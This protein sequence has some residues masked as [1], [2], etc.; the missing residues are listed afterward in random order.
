MTTRR[1]RDALQMKQDILTAANQIAEKEGFD[2]ISIRKIAK[3]IEYTPSLIYHYFAS[4]EEIVS[5]LLKQGYAKLATSLATAAKSVEAPKQK[6]T[7]MTRAFLKTALEIP[8]E[9][10]IV[11]TDD[12]ESVVQHTSYLFK[13]AAEKRIAIQMLARCIQDMNQGREMDDEQSE[14]T[15]QSI[16]AATMG[17]ALKLIVEK[18]LDPQQREK[19]ISYFSE[20]VVVRMASLEE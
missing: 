3:M 5:V 1:E 7:A 18:N 10:T 4:K 13:G 15:A 9:F 12:A 14:L 17:M 20:T 16:A 8:Q 6:L 19:I 2:A 11:H